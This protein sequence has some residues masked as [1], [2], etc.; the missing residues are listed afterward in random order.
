[1]VRCSRVFAHAL[2]C[3]LVFLSVSAWAADSAVS[4]AAVPRQ[5]AKVPTEGSAASRGDEQAAPAAEEPLPKP[6]AKS[7]FAL[8]MGDV[9]SQPT[10][11]VLIEEG[12]DYSYYRYYPERR[13][14]FE[15]AAALDPGSRDSARALIY[16]AETTTA[17]DRGLQI[18]FARSDSLSAAAMIALA[19]EYGWNEDP[20]AERGWLK[21]AAGMPSGADTARATVLLAEALL[22]TG[23]RT[24]AADLLVQVRDQYRD[25]EIVAFADLVQ[26][27]I[28]LT[29]KGGGHGRR[30]YSDY[31]VMRKL[32]AAAVDQ[33]RGTFLGGWA[34]IRLAALYRGPL[35]QP[36]QAA[37]ILARTAQ[38]Y[39]GT[40]FSEYAL[41]DLAATITFS[42]GRFPEGR[43]RY[44]Q[45][46]ATTASDFIR[47][48]ATLHLGELLMDTEEYGE[49]YDL[50]DDFITTWP[51][52]VD[53]VGVRMLRGYVASRLNWWEEA[54]AD[55]NAYLQV[56][57]R[58]LPAYTG[59]AHLVL[60][61]AAYDR[62]DLG[63]AE[64]Q[65]ASVDDE[66]LSPE[67]KAGVG[68]CRA[69]RG[70]L[71]GAMSA[72]LEAAALADP[73]NAPL[74]FYQAAR[75]AQRLGDRNTFGQILTRMIAGF[76]GDSLTAVVAGREIL[77]A[78][79][80]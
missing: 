64:D 18:A 44:E 1:M 37:A 34:S 25:P 10:A 24:T 3:A 67:G 73:R 29:P 22:P 58:R 23:D 50:F 41:E 76:P 4:A 38:D 40:P 27:L 39:G 9:P 45:L 56:T 65:F 75:L 28:P 26:G 12:L 15:E 78:P 60:A 46:L 5:V 43:A 54:V 51:Q 74:D 52:H 19:A 49:A 7:E 57:S 68:Y 11:A 31:D 35:G 62:G 20:E 69:D 55:A 71:R 13:A 61:R 36:D 77:P 80:I 63:A 32:C 66:F 59:K 53:S 30:L 14:C 8:L 33:W 6:T 16:L 72:F 47:Q 17:P 42:F 48:R 70:D 21:A 2:A 79:G